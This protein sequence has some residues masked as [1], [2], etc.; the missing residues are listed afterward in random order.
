MYQFDASAR[1]LNPDSDNADKEGYVPYLV[2][3]KI[4]IQ[5][6]GPEWTGFNEGELGKVYKAFTTQ[7]GIRETM[8]IVLSGTTTISGTKFKVT[9]IEEWNGPMGQHFEVVLRKFSEV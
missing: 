9:G 6:A 2:N 4:N 1:E 5:P 3:F 7:S 8:Q